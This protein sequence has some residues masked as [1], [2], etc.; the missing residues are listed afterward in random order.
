MAAKMCEYAGDI[1]ATMKSM[2]EVAPATSQDESVKALWANHDAHAARLRAELRREQTSRDEA[3]L[4]FSKPRHHPVGSYDDMM[5][6]RF[7]NPLVRRSMAA[8]QVNLLAQG[9]PQNKIQTEGRSRSG[10]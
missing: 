9:R 6:E 8:V 1:A 3:T 4:R 10:G 2:E 7:K 5:R